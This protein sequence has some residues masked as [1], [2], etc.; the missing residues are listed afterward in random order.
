MTTP[1]NNS[2]KSRE[3]ELPEAVRAEAAV[4]L[5]RLH[6][7]QR[8]EEMEQS[9]RTWLA[10]N[11]QRAAAFERMTNTWEATGG[12]RS[13]ERIAGAVASVPT[14]RKRNI[15][16][17]T[18]SQAVA[19]CVILGIV[20]TFAT[21][22]LGFG[23]TGPQTRIE[24]ALG[25]RRSLQ[26]EDGSRVML[27]TNSRVSVVYT[28]QQRLINL[29]RGQARFEVAKD[30]ARL[31]IVRAGGKQI[32]ARGTQFDVR[33]TDERLSIV[34]LEGS[35]SVLPVQQSPT[36]PGIGMNPGERLSFEQPTIAVKS[37]PNLA[38]EEAWVAGRAI[39][40]HTPLREAVAEI[41]RYA[42]RPLELG[43]PSL[44][45]LRISGTFSVDDVDAF[46][47]ALAEVLSLSVEESEAAIVLRKR[48][49]AHI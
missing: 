19:A 2:R 36:R 3:V 16:W 46:A 5:A 33:W 43:D 45:E 1:S 26:L 28:D 8:T 7:D 41:N 14:P 27:N 10:G 18:L 44:A 35:V 34:L 42:R 39:F 20:I 12:L 40:E 47:R 30:A 15:A 32:V 11:A 49:P 37:A 29:E 38:R 4:W 31:F 17:A 6:S 13:R 24:T 22:L 21:E 25:E 48:M 9:F 23:K